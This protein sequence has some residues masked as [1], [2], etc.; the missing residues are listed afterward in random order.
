M[1]LVTVRPVRWA[2]GSDLIRANFESRSYHAPWVQPFLD[3]DGF[4]NWF[5]Q[6]L[7]GPNVSL[8]AHEEQTGGIVGLFNISQIV[9]GGFRSA[10][11]G[12]FGMAAFARRGLMTEAL[13]QAA[14]HAFMEICLHRL[15]A[16]IQ[17][18]NRASIALV[19][20]VG[21]RK[22][23]YSPQYLRIAGEWRDHERWTLLSSDL[24]DPA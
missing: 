22:E 21:F 5:G 19:R 12:Y 10:Y 20:R 4:E 13:H 9:W 24:R 8:I 15:E 11:L 2:D 7:T 14:R 17:P 23:G 1:S 16:N 6:L 18:S 3:R